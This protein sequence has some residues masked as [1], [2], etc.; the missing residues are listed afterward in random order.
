MLWV[1]HLII[2]KARATAVSTPAR[3][4]MEIIIAPVTKMIIFQ[5]QLGKMKIPNALLMS[6]IPTAST[7]TTKMM[8]I[9]LNAHVAETM[10]SGMVQSMSVNNADGAETT[11]KSQ[12]IY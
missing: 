4:E 11:I 9:Q 5:L 3:S 2:W 1:T 7:T 10:H 8:T 6:L 12:L